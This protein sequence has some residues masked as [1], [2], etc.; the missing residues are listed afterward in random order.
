MIN[1]MTA[2]DLIGALINLTP[3][4]PD[5]LEKAEMIIRFKEKREAAE[6]QLKKEKSLPKSDGPDSVPAVGRKSIQIFTQSENMCL[7][8][9]WFLN[10]DEFT[11]VKYISDI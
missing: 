2:S 7:I 9:T 5:F 1:K 10:K 3:F 11:Q 6:K 4:D 8:R